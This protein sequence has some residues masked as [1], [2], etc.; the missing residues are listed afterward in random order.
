VPDRRGSR[1]CVYVYPDG[2]EKAGR[3]CRGWVHTEWINAAPHFVHVLGY[4]DKDH[5]PILPAPTER[6]QSG[7]EEQHRADYGTSPKEVHCP[8]DRCDHARLVAIG[9]RHGSPDLDRYEKGD[10]L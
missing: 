9:V 3:E 1:H 4:L 10:V 8:C 2:H 6:Q 7:L 5:A